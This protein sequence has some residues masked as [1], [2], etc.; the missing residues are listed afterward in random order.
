MTRSPIQALPPFG[1]AIKRPA[2]YLEIY[3]T[4]STSLSTEHLVLSS[5]CCPEV[6]VSMPQ[7]SIFRVSDMAVSIHRVRPYAR[8]L[9]HLDFHSF[10][11]RFSLIEMFYLTSSSSPWSPL[12][13]SP[14]LTTGLLQ[15]QFWPSAEHAFLGQPDC[16]VGRCFLNRA[17]WTVSTLLVVTPFLLIQI[18]PFQLRWKVNSIIARMELILMKS[19]E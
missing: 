18:R 9:V 1:I 17:V 15:T 13:K 6:S 5:S 16:A 14:H 2:S 11:S 10:V 12:V 3:S 19:I 4:K 7:L 8:K